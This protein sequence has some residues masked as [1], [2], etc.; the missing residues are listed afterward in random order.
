MENQKKYFSFIEK[1]K[2]PKSIN[3]I[4]HGRKDSLFIKKILNNT[5]VFCLPSLSEGTPIAL[6]ESMSMQSICMVSKESN[7]SKIIK[8][9]YNGFEFRLNEKSFFL[10]LNKILSLSFSK[11]I[12]I[13]NNA[14]STVIKNNI[15]FKL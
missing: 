5:D 13:R 6:L 12:K 11:Q 9:K 14:R 2:F 7:L 15:K 4:F 1:L 3:V 10:T 8:N